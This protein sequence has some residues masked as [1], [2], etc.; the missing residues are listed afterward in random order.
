MADGTNN[1]PAG[2]GSIN[3]NIITS[4]TTVTTTQGDHAHSVSGSCSTGGASARHAHSITAE[5]G[6]AAANNMPP[7]QV[8]NKLI[9]VL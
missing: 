4:R 1:V 8:M 2:G 6:G 5:G 9:R 7:Y 3:R